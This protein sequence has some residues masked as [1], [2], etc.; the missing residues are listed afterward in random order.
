MAGC[1]TVGCNMA[2]TVY[3]VRQPQLGWHFRTTDTET[4]EEWSTQNVVITART[5]SD[6]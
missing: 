6:E 5:V 1:T 2:T 4:A 3:S